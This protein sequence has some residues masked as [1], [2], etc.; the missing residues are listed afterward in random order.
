MIVRDFDF[1]CALLRPVKTHT[2]LVVDADAVLA[3]SVAAQ[4]FEPI[5]RSEPRVIQ[6]D[7]RHNTLE[8]HACPALDVSRQ[9]TNRV[10]RRL[11]KDPDADDRRSIGTICRDTLKNSAFLVGYLECPCGYTMKRQQQRSPDCWRSRCYDGE[12][13]S[14][15]VGH[16]HLLQNSIGCTQKHGDRTHNEG[17]FK[18]CSILVASCRTSA[19]WSGYLIGFYRM[20]K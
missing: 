15:S 16:T 3:F 14:T 6:R 19:G 12:S 5:R 7:G 11:K 9:T 1:H 2:P 8:P 18:D 20:Y 13:T 17:E 4:S 10:S